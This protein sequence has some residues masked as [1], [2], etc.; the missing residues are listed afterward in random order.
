LL[1]VRLFDRIAGTI[2]GI[3]IVTSVVLFELGYDK[4][5]YYAVVLV[6]MAAI[7]ILVYRSE[8]RRRL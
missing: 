5:P 6:T 2:V 1:R 8:V 3:G 7:A 4:T